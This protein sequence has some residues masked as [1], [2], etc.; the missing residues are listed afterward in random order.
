MGLRWAQDS[1]ETHHRTYENRI[2]RMKKVSKFSK[3]NDSARISV[4]SD[5]SLKYSS[6][7]NETNV[8]NLKHDNQIQ[9]IAIQNQIYRLE[10]VL[11]IIPRLL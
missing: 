2:K 8:E 11:L 7:D 9:N 4:N 3:T 10:Q 1:L 5:H 6:C